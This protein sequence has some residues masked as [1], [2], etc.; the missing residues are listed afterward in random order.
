MRKY[1][2]SSAV[3]K[4]AIKE[5]G[6]EPRYAPE[7]KIRISE[8][9]DFP[10]PGKITALRFIQ[11]CQKNSAGVVSL[12]TG[13]TPVHFI[14]WTFFILKNW[15]ERMCNDFLILMELIMLPGQIYLILFLCISTIFI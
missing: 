10:G 5:S 15:T 14:Y 13:K 3:E 1:V 11:W 8:V 4:I 7:E 9:S 2:Y 12:P 6:F